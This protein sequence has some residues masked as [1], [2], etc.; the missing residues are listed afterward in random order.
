MQSS[1]RDLLED[2]SLATDL[3]AT[4][5]TKEYA[6]QRVAENPRRT[7]FFRPLQSADFD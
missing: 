7:S 1:G 2:F 6:T 3:G 5:Q 4:R